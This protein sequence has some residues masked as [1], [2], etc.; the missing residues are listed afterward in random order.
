[1]FWLDTDFLSLSSEFSSVRFIVFDQYA[2]IVAQHQLEFPQYYDQPGYELLALIDLY[3]DNLPPL[4]GIH[5]ML[6]RSKLALINVC[7]RL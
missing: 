6:L 3:C 7:P 5:M 1:M 4:D 2:N